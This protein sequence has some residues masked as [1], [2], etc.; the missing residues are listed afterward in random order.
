MNN[1]QNKTQRYKLSFTAIGLGL[2]ESIKVADVYLTCQN[3]DATREILKQENTLQSRTNRRDVRIVREIIHRL[4]Q[5]TR[6]QL[7]LLVDGDLVDQRLLLW[8]AVCN[9]YSLIQEFAVEVLHEK[10]LAMD[11][12]LSETDYRAFILRKIDWHP[13]L[14]GIKESTQKKI[15]TVLFRMMRESNLLDDEDHIQRVLPSRKLS[16]AL[17]SHAQFAYQLYPAFPNE[18]G[19]YE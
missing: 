12:H 11:T 8:F 19:V 18:F 2:S 4:S 5:L 6:D 15:R 1:I 14:D 10:F 13:E 7:E 3:W 9:Y 17:K 16:K